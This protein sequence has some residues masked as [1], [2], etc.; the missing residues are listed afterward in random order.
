L[1]WSRVAA[2]LRKNGGWLGSTQ[3][4]RIERCDLLW[5]T[6]VIFTFFRKFS[7]MFSDRFETR[8]YY[9]R[10]TGDQAGGG[11]AKVRGVGRIIISLRAWPRI[12]RFE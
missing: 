4:L 8:N 10:L 5:A 2:Q 12:E 11:I 9:L 1:E 6:Q 3:I 7:G